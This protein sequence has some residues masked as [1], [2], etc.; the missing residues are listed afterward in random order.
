MTTA[1]EQVILS[2][3]TKSKA[4]GHFASYHRHRN[5]FI[6]DL[7]RGIQPTEIWHRIRA[8]FFRRLGITSLEILPR[9]DLP[10][11]EAPY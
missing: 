4:A 10:L 8:L 1:N 6:R 9:A 7:T 2:R 3:S 11:S 5:P